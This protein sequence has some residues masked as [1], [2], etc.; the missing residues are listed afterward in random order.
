MGVG[1][2]LDIDLG[3][4][5][6]YLT[7]KGRTNKWDCI[8]LKRFSTAK[9]TTDKMKK[10]PMKLEKTF[11]N[12]IFNR[13]LI[14]R[15]TGTHT[16]KYQKKNKQKSQLKMENH[17]NRHCFKEDIHENVLITNQGSAKK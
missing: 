12:H 1:N 17:L 15:Y 9:E 6:L 10:Q 14:S 3:N 7:P 8:K 5:F 11:A 2:L 13:G 16:S 4:Y